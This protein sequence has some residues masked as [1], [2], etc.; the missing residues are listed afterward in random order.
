YASWQR[1][2]QVSAGVE[3]T[4]DVPVL[5]VEALPRTRA[6]SPAHPAAK[7]TAIDRPARV[8]DPWAARRALGWVLGGVG[9]GAIVAGA[10]AGV[11]AID[12]E[13]SAS[14]KCT[15]KVCPDKD[16]LAESDRAEAAARVST[17]AF[18]AGT[19]LLGAGV[20]ILLTAPR[21]KTTV[22]ITPMASR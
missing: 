12:Q 3:L 1:D 6:A 8:G 16:A 7:L 18:I 21:A 9:A 4:V 13:S 15:E 10:I 11:V 19:A 17:V 20:V 5:D 14:D 2:V 22:A